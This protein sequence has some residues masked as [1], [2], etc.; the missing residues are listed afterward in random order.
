MSKL[1]R[2]FGLLQA[3]ALNISNVVGVGPFITI[4]LMLAT[5]NGPQALLGWLAGALLAVCDGMV[6]SELGAAWP[7]S[8][9]S[10]RFLRA[11]YGPDRWGRLMAFLFIWQFIL[12]GPLEIAS[13]LIGFSQYISFLAPGLTPFHLKLIA[14]GVGFVAFAL[15]YRGIHGLSK[16]TVTLW[17][18]ATVTL[19][20]VPLAG[21]GHFNPKLAFSFP[22]HAFDFSKGFVL[23]L[24]SAMLIAIYDYMG[25]YDVCYIGDEVREPSRTIPRSIFYCILFSACAYLALETMIIGVVPW[26][27]AIQSRFIASEYMQQLHGH[28]A[29]VGITI[30]ILWTA[31]ASV[32]ALLF[33]YSRIPFAAA[34]DGYFFAPFARLHETKNFPHVSL[35]VISVVAIIA[36]FFPLD[37]VISALITTRILVQFIAQILALP[38]LRTRLNNKLP[39]RMPLYPFP[40]LVALMGWLY[41]FGASGWLYI[42]FGLLSLAAGFAVFFL[43]ARINDTWP[44][45]RSVTKQTAQ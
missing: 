7:G 8:G 28:A 29:A 40:A 44:F 14:A 5:M 1:H 13:G 45:V 41:I 26:Q 16:L 18:G 22:P 25:Y 4:P 24:G 6:W 11:A 35:S 30:L 23:G 15:L 12:S 2:G 37:A 34:R 20:A 9:G 32:F 17:I 10:Y 39:F 3:T 38:L 31:F 42:R 27:Q 33:G 36:A 19:I 43:Q 21:I